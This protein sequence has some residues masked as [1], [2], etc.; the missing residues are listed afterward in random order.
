[1]K[2]SEEVLD[3]DVIA[4]LRELS[5]DDDETLFQ[6]LL[7]LYLDDSTKQMERLERSLASGDLKQAERIAH[8]LKSSSANLGATAMS[9]LCL[10][11]ELCGRKQSLL[12]MNALLEPARD[13]HR[14]AVLALEALRN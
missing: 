8:T 4:A 11:M 10:E 9:K 6:E 7:D 5:G 2:H 12:E 1:M 3:M 14:R 13:A